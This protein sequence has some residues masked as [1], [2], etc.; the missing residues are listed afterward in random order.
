MGLSQ[1]AEEYAGAALCGGTLGKVRSV[2]FVSLSLPL[3]AAFLPLSLLCIVSPIQLSLCHP[4]LRLSLSHFSFDV[5][6]ADSERL[7]FSFLSLTIQVQRAASV[8]HDHGGAAGPATATTARLSSSESSLTS[9]W[10][11]LRFYQACRSM[12]PGTVPTP[13]RN[14]LAG[15]SCADAFRQ[16]SS[17]DG[18]AFNK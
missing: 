16:R 13:D 17:Q 18:L 8:R 7:S 2:R 11:V 5:A 10:P 9:R 3:S 1:A 4:I 14:R 15:R 6:V 12:T